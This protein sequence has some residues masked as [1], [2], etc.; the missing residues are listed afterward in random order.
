MKEPRPAKTIQFHVNHSLLAG[1]A[2]LSILL[3][4]LYYK[5][6]VPLVQ[7]WIDLPDFSHGFLVPLISLYLLW[8]RR[9]RLKRP[10]S[11]SNWGL[12][13]L[14][15]GL[16]ILLFGRLAAEVFTQRLSI[17]IVIAGIVLFLLGKEHL[18]TI[19]FPLAFLLLMIP[20]PSILLQK[21]TFPMQLFASRCAAGALELLS[22]PVFREGNVINLANTSLEVAEACS[23][24]R[25]VI[26]LLALGVLFAYF[27]KKILWQRIVVVFASLPIAILVN[28]FRVT[29]TGYLSHFYGA[30]AAQGFFHEFSGFILFLMAMALFY[31][32][33]LFLS[34]LTP[35]QK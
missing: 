15:F 5:T 24:I 2:V 21:I 29:M 30:K 12:L 32:L 22:I 13:L 16:I 10:F 19:A 25:S 31:A 34:W 9:E 7:D 20:L 17:L 14:A 6:L 23:G 4:I 11:A 33:T 3:V 8:E 1:V 35:A 18:K 27:T 28:A 26:S